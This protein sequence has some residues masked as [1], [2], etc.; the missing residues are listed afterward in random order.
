MREL[1][2]PR[3]VCTLYEHC[4][5]TGKKCVSISCTN[6]LDRKVITETNADIKTALLIDVL[7]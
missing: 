7:S 3:T 6:T 2:N 1:G 4:T 5:L